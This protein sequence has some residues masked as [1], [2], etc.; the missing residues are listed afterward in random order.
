MGRLSVCGHCFPWLG[1]LIN[2]STDNISGKYKKVDVNICPQIIPLSLID[3][4]SSLKKAM[5]MMT[6]TMT[7][8]TSVNMIPL[9]GVRVDAVNKEI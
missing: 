9:N 6:R 5:I 2:G 1:P 7:R 3:I 4:D 8:R